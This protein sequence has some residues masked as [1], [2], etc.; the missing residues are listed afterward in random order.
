LYDQRGK[1]TAD[2]VTLLEED[3]RRAARLTLHH[4]HDPARKRTLE[5][6]QLQRLEPLLIPVMEAGR[7]LADPPSLEEMRGNRQAD[8]DRL[9]PGVQRLV[10]PHLY[11]VSLSDDLWALKSR[12]VV[13][14]R[15]ET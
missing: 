1:A 8:I 5:L 13:A 4:P 11:H 15:P 14:A 10:N 7:R 9:D 12:L 6:D 3:P 2:L